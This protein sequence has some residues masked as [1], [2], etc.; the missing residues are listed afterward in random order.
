M[1]VFTRYPQISAAA[2]RKKTGTRK[3]E[4]LIEK[5]KSSLNLSFS[6]NYIETLKLL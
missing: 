5:K 1:Q 4:K 6:K 3:T 2:D